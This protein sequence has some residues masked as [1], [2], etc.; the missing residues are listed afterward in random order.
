VPWGVDALSG[1]VPNSPTNRAP[2]LGLVQAIPNLRAN[3]IVRV[4][5]ILFVRL[6]PPAAESFHKRDG[7]YKLLA[8]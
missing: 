7:G 8:A 4:V 5:S 2:S 3:I 6:M 1:A